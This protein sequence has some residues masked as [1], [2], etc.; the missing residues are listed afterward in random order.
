MWCNLSIPA[1][2]GIWCS[3]S[4]RSITVPH[5]Q[6]RTPPVAPVSDYL[7]E[8]S[9][10]CVHVTSF[11]SVFSSICICLP[12]CLLI[13][14]SVYL[15]SW[16]SICLSTCVLICLSLG[17]DL[18][19][20][21]LKSLCLDTD[22]LVSFLTSNTKHC[23]RRLLL[24]PPLPLPSLTPSS[25]PFHSCSVRPSF[26]KGFFFLWCPSKPA[27]VECGC[28][29][30]VV[31]DDVLVTSLVSCEEWQAWRLRLSSATK[32]ICI[33][34]C[35]SREFSYPFGD[36]P[37]DKQVQGKKCPRVT[38]HKKTELHSRIQN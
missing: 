23:L 5:L 35:I 27:L 38:L 11:S 32:I 17:R 29:D 21:F 36:K 37:R 14:L 2:G 22:K 31:C 1:G 6:V 26:V 3:A 33:S 19:G 16:I 15:S 30:I 28:V 25:P 24:P 7:A 18:Q 13:Y 9:T 4:I 34:I 20:T 12:I 8:K 10:W